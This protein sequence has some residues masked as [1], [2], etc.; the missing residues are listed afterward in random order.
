MFRT[1]Y[2]KIIILK[3]LK[4]YQNFTKLAQKFFKKVEDKNEQKFELRIF[5]FRRKMKSIK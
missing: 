4:L 2:N 1:S 5:L 3:K